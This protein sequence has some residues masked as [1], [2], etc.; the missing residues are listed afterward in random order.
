MNPSPR[1]QYG[2]LTRLVSV[3][4]CT[5]N[6]LCVPCVR[7]LPQPLEWCK[8]VNAPDATCMSTQPEEQAS[9]HTISVALHSILLLEVNKYTYL[10]VCILVPRNMP[11]GTEL[12]ISSILSLSTESKHERPAYKIQNKSGKGFTLYNVQVECKTS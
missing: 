5:Y 4:L 8:Q 1:W 3:E 6:G 9:K 12:G 7:T 10:Q 11:S 2:S